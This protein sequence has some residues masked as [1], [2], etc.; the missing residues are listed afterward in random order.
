MATT[1]ANTVTYKTTFMLQ[2][3]HGCV[4]LWGIELA[5][6]SAKTQISRLYAYKRGRGSWKRIMDTGTLYWD[7]TRAP[8]DP[9]EA[10]RSQGVL[11]FPSLHGAPCR[12]TNLGSYVSEVE[13]HLP[14]KDT[15]THTHKH[16]HTHTN[17]HTHTHTH[18]HKTHCNKQ[19]L[20]NPGTLPG[21]YVLDQALEIMSLL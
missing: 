20:K 7:T 4:L 17:T 13:K 21:V 2:Y 8:L 12:K 14:K 5:S 3:V 18:T 10:G 6:E 15:N 19:R 11:T 1:L 16:T 9:M